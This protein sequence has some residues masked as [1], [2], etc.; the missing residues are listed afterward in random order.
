MSLG[1]EHQR[2]YRRARTAGRTGRVAADSRPTTD[3]PAGVPVRPPS[4][5]LAG[6]RPWARRSCTSPAQPAVL[7]GHDDAGRYLLDVHVDLGGRRGEVRGVVESSARACMTPS[8]ACP[9]TAAS[10]PSARAPA[11]S[12]DTSHGA[13]QNGLHADGPCPT[14]LRRAPVRTATS[15]AGWPAC[16][17]RWSGGAGRRGSSLCR[18]SMAQVGQHH[19]GQ[20]LHPAGR[21]GRRGDSGGTLTGRPVEPVP[22]WRGGLLGEPRDL[23]NLLGNVPTPARNRPRAAPLPVELHR[24]GP[25]TIDLLRRRSV[26]RPAR[27]A[28][29]ARSWA[30]P[31]AI[32][33]RPRPAGGGWPRSRRTAC[34]TRSPPR[35][36]DRRGTRRP[37]GTRTARTAR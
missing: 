7:H 24:R 28:S 25:F 5:R 6:H 2:Q 35:R 36:Q 16:A 31:A 37:S 32:R 17:V 18:S 11:G 13:A 33:T 8:A 3:R 15:P 4:G 14:T 21:V 19:S 12:G 10:R 30:S 22:T 1:D 34:T 9:A 23:L 29:R 26:P 27:S 20:R